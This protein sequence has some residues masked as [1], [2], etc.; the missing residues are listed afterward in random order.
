M[1]EMLDNFFRWLKDVTYLKDLIIR[2]IV[3]TPLGIAAFFLWFISIPLLLWYVY[4]KFGN[5]RI[6]GCKCQ[7]CT[8]LNDCNDK[9]CIYCG[10][11]MNV[12]YGTSH[13]QYR[14]QPLNQKKKCQNCGFENEADAKFCIKCGKTSFVDEAVYYEDETIAGYL[15]TLL[16]YIAK[17]DDVISSSEAAFISIILNDLSLGDNNTR[18][19][20]KEIFKRAKDKTNRDH[21]NI[22]NKLYQ[23][24]TRE[25]DTISAR[26][27]FLMLSATF[28]MALVYIDENLNVKQNVIVTEILKNLHFTDAQIKDL[29]A[30][31]QETKHTDPNIPN[32]KD[33]ASLNCIASDSDEKIKRSYRELAKQYHPDT[34]Q[35]QKLPEAIMLLA[36]EKFK[37][38]N[39]AYEKIK[40]YRGIK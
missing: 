17:G 14:P 18:E 9:F 34:L 12:P 16:A 20:L 1:K 28:F 4:A 36:T 35:A 3:L 29:H 39:S 5:N 10:H 37:E 19:V 22:S 11:G 8:K 21:K 40:K 24:V 25:I 33:Y 6:A 13:Q 23:E 38:I 27:E 26:N 15:V 32:D 2:A 31:F 7:K 30:E